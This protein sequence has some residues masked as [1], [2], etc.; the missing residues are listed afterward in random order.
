[1]TKQDFVRL[2]ALNSGLTESQAEQ[3]VNAMPETCGRFTRDYGASGPG[4]YNAGYS[5]GFQF[6]MTRQA[7]PNQWGLNITLDVDALSDFGNGSDRF[8]LPVVNQ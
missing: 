2:L 1:M 6:A 8:G 3:A 7:S 4:Q 5:G